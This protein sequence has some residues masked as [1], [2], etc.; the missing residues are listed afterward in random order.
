MADQKQ[1]TTFLGYLNRIVRALL[2]QITVVSALFL[3]AIVLF[4]HGVHFGSGDHHTILVAGSVVL[5]LLSC[6][7]MLYFLSGLIRK[8]LQKLITQISV[9]DAVAEHAFHTIVGKMGAVV[10]VLILGLL[11]LFLYGVIEWFHPDFIHELTS[12]AWFIPTSF[13]ASFTQHEHWVAFLVQ[14]YMMLLIALTFGIVVITALY[15]IAAQI[16]SSSA[17]LSAD[18][19][20][21]EYDLLNEDLRNPSIIAKIVGQVTSR[22]LGMSLLLFEGAIFLAAMLTLLSIH[23]SHLRFGLVSPAQIK[24]IIIAPIV[25]Y[26]AVML[27][28]F[29]VSRIMRL[30]S[31]FKSYSFQLQVVYLVLPLL[32]LPLLHFGHLEVDVIWAACIA[33]VLGSL[34]IGI[35]NYISVETHPM[36]GQIIKDANKGAVLPFIHGIKKGFLY[37]LLPFFAVLIIVIMAWIPIPSN[38]L[39]AEAM[40][41]SMRVALMASFILISPTALLIQ[42]TITDALGDTVKSCTH[43]F[44]LNEGVQKRAATISAQASMDTTLVQNILLFTGFVG[45][46]AIPLVNRVGMTHTQ[47]SNETV[48]H[49]FGGIQEFM[50]GNIMAPVLLFISIG[51]LLS[52]IYRAY[53][54]ATQNAFRQIQKTPI[55]S[56]QVLPVFDESIETILKSSKRGIEIT[57]SLV[58]LGVIFTLLS[59]GLSASKSILIAA[60]SIV[61]A[62]SVPLMMTANIWARAKQILITYVIDAE[63]TVA[64]ST[65]TL[66]DNMGVVLKTTV[67][68][69]L[70]LILK[71]IGLFILVLAALGV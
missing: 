1:I 5:G 42:M 23:F 39:H 69:L 20:Q 12:F 31:G 35:N 14:E 15:N 67:F 9:S 60:S 7:G 70:I 26:A 30:I 41:V 46:M 44:M 6:I 22:G 47:L 38:L 34:F 48:R 61:F 32:L 19:V 50:I 62:L 55:L 2:G 24:A 53:H 16:F 13:F 52:F 66:L 10:S 33:A 64:Y 28:S 25:I 54:K 58:L 71:L 11:L 57:G 21:N 59:V 45:V 27:L 68:P 40:L 8:A 29:I 17:K 37:A 65:L 36:Y 43:I 49:G 18:A 51:L 3:L 63:D 4:V 56:G